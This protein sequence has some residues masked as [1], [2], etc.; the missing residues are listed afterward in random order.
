[1][2]SM[3]FRL[4]APYSKYIRVS[5]KRVAKDFDFG[6]QANFSC[7]GQITRSRNDKW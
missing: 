7:L 1:M 5:R 2:K 3:I 6:S 4:I